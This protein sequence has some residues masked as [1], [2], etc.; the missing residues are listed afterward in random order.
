MV[1]LEC[2]MTKAKLEERL[3][4]AEAIA[5]QLSVA[6]CKC[7]VMT[8]AQENAKYAALEAWLDYQK[9]TDYAD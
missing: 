5:Q 9:E 4:K 8:P 6:L 7:P 1:A 2:S 3:E